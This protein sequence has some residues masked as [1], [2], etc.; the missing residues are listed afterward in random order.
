MVLYVVALHFDSFRVSRLI[1][2]GIEEYPDTMRNSA[3]ALRKK[4]KNNAFPAP[5]CV[6]GYVIIFA[7]LVLGKSSWHSDTGRCW[8]LGRSIIGR[9]IIKRIDETC[10]TCMVAVWSTAVKDSSWAP[11]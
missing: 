4:F 8:G 11:L 7:G 9:R 3:S 6:V 1:F 2:E 10:L 5:G